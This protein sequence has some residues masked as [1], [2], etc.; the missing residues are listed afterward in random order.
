WNTYHERTKP[1]SMEQFSTTLRPNAEVITVFVRVWK[2]WGVPY[3]EIDVNLDAIGLYGPPF[4]APHGPGPVHPS[5]GN[6]GSGGPGYATEQPRGSGGI[7]GPVSAP[8]ASPP[9]YAPARHEPVRPE[10]AHVTCGGENLVYN[11]N[12]EDGFGPIGQGEIGRGWSAFANGGAVHV[13]FRAEEWTQVISD[14]E[15]GQ[16]IEISSQSIYPTDADRYAGI[17]Q[18]IGG[19]RPGEDYELT[20]HG[21]LRGTNG[22]HDDYRFDAQWGITAGHQ[23]DWRHVEERERLDL[24]VIYPLEQPVSM[25]SH[26][27]RFTAP[28]ASV[29]LYI[30]GWKKWG[31]TNEQMILNLDRITLHACGGHAGPGGPGVGGP[32]HPGGG[33]PGPAQPPAYP[34]PVAPNQPGSGHLDKDI[35]CSYTV[36]AGDTLSAIAVRFD[37]SMQQLSQANGI[38]N[39]NHIYVGQVLT[40]PGCTQ[41]PPQPP[42]G[43]RPGHDDGGDYGDGDKPERPETGVRSYTVR[44]GDSLSAIAV[45]FDVSQQ[46]LAHANGISNPNH[47]YVGQVLRIP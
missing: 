13:G 24:G 19:L 30:R 8:V 44:A 2:K 22:S 45:R 31:V 6:P 41:G 3:E 46:Q 39:A 7:G 15:Y 5:A 47:I 33:Q 27:V 26:T 20:V 35:V 28:A 25:N 29:V 23:D 4:V 38:Q 1:G 12:F 16:A 32:V 40:V 37:V 43:P 21:L 17:A 14:G 10:P 36:R 18:R 9:G 11:G 34:G 42:V